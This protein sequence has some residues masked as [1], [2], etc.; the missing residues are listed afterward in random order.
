LR[1]DIKKSEA[2]RRYDIMTGQNLSKD[3]SYLKEYKSKKITI[4]DAY[5]VPKVFWN[6]IDLLK[7]NNLVYSQQKKDTLIEVE[8]YKVQDYKTVSSA[9]EG[10]YIHRDTKDCK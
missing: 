8:S 3:I 6:V 4:P 5:I 7:S 2:D 10:H 1:Q 9:Y